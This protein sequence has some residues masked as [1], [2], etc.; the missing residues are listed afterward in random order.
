M[1]PMKTIADLKGEDLR[2]V[3]P[4]LFKHTYELRTMTGDVV[5]TI[6]RTGLFR[7]VDEAEAAGERWTIAHVGGLTRRFEIRQ[8]DAPDSAPR[9]VLHHQ[10]CRLELPGGGEVRWEKLGGEGEA[11][12]QWTGRDGSCLMKLSSGGGERITSRI[13]LELGA[14]DAGTRLLLA[15]LGSYLILLY[16]DEVE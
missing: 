5:A 4:S 15:L 16:G 3:Q 1:K 10:G 2:W 14:A 11:V 6:T 13:R 12:W 8:A 9:Y 7:E